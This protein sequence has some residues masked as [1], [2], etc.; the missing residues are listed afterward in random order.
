MAKDMMSELVDELFDRVDDLTDEEGD[1]FDVLSEHTDDFPPDF[2][3]KKTVE[4]LNKHFGG[5][6]D[7]KV[8]EKVRLALHAKQTLDNLMDELAGA[9]GDLPETEDDDEDED[10]EE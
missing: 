1:V 5:H 8:T 2:F 7:M 10:D 9:M 6:D 4:E 3:M